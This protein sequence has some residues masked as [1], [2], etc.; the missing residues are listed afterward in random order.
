MNE[1]EIKDLLESAKANG[2][3]SAEAFNNLSADIK[4]SNIK[5]D[6]GLQGILN[7]LK[8]AN[9]KLTVQKEDNATKPE[10]TNSFLSDKEKTMSDSKEK[11]NIGFNRLIIASARDYKGIASA[12]QK[13]ALAEY[14]KNAIQSEGTTT[15]GGYLL[16]TPTASLVIDDLRASGLFFS[17]TTMYDM[18]TN[19]LKIPTIAA[20]GHPSP[21]RVAA[22]AA[23]PVSNYTFGQI[24]LNLIKY[25]C[26]IPWE[27]E[28]NQDN[29]VMDFEK[30]I[31]AYTA[32]YFGILFDNIL[33]RGD[34]YINGIEDF[35]TTYQTTSG[36]AFTSFTDDDIIRMIGLLRAG[37]LVGAEFYM[38][39]S[40]W[41][42]IGTK[43]GSDGHALVSDYA[44][45]TRTLKGFP[46]NLTDSAYAMSESGAGKT[47]MTLGNLKKVYVGTQNG[48]T[49]Q[50]DK[51][52]SA[53][54]IDG[55]TTVH[56]FQQN[57]TVMRLEKRVD[58]DIAFPTRLVQLRSAAA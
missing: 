29:P 6:E 8:S 41:A 25:A 35:T 51:S 34:A 30:L 11:Y 28:F 39:P 38:S 27:D 49:F 53:S 33:F 21:S 26:L 9:E 12:E 36:T 56:G 5:L 45:A 44:Y 48:M 7:E 18:Y 46:V 22:G 42:E 32:D 52:N 20:T 16:P 37:D 57:V 15:T 23:K 58:M 54:Y 14:Y 1:Q 4:N 40:V 43:R 50:M 19:T 13:N 2:T 17:K 10:W 24:T 3:M 31:R 47:I 55:E